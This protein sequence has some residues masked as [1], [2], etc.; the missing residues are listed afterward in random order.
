MS[1]NM[2]RALLSTLTSEFRS[3]G[4]TTI[5]TSEAPELIGAGKITN[6]GTSFIVDAVVMLRFVEIGSEMKKA[7]NVL[8]VRGSRHVRE[9]REYLISEKGITIGHKFEGVVGLMSGTPR[10]AI[11]DEVEGFFKK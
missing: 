9:I 10:K 3:R 4:I 6:T 8:K 7:L 11:A 2:L 5:L 1:E